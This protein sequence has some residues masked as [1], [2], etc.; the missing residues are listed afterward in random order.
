MPRYEVGSPWLNIPNCEG[1][2]G[3]LVDS[4][5][6]MS[7]LCT[8]AAKKANAIL[9]C[10]NRGTVSGSRQ[11]LVALYTALMRPH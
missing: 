11:A 7:Q 5:L 9:G 8:A 10:I 4:C 2:L 3:V 6:S 1:N